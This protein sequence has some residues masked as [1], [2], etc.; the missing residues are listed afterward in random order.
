MS[1][2]EERLVVYGYVQLFTDLGYELRG[3]LILGFGRLNNREPGRCLR[4]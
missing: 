2:D 4:S 1:T 3:R